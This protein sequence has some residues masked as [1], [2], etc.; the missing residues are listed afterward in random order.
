MWPRGVR[1][2]LSLL[3]CFFLMFNSW[4][5]VNTYG[6]FASYYMETL[7]PGRDLL[8]LNLIGSTES[9]IVLFFSFIVGR[10]LDAG[11]YQWLTGAGWILV[12]LGM[13]ALSQTT[14]VLTQNAVAHTVGNYGLIWATQG[15]TTGL[16]MACFFVSSS[17]SEHTLRNNTVQANVSPFSSRFHL[18]PKS[19]GFCNRNCCLWGECW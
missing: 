6:T 3:G 12:S 17:Q 19:E 15:F 16:G 11:Y 2:Y 10:L 18:V 14:K 8:L 5:L 9:F 7:L 13:F 1:P 4:G